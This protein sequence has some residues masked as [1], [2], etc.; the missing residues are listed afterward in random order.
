MNSRVNSYCSLPVKSVKKHPNTLQIQSNRPT[1]CH[2]R[3]NIHGNSVIT[4]GYDLPRCLH[5]FSI[6]KSAKV[7]NSI[8][9]IS[10]WITSYLAQFPSYGW[11]LVT[12]SLARGECLTLTLSPGW[13]PAN[14]VINDI[15]LKTRFFGLHFRCRKYWSIFNHFYAIRPEIYGIRWNYSPDRGITPFKV[16]QGHRV[17]YQSKARMRFTISD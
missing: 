14:I 16:I 8:D 17:L 5:S 9:I 7:P 1:V 3:Q 11:L 4:A 2:R 13:S 6:R 15:S 12:F 10:F